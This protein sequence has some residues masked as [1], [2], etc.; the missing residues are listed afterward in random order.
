MVKLFQSVSQALITSLSHQNMLR[1]RWNQRVSDPFAFTP[2]EER[3]NISLET[4]LRENLELGKFGTKSLIKSLGSSSQAEIL[5]RLSHGKKMVGIGYG[6]GY[7]AAS[8]REVTLKGLSTW[9]LEISDISC[10]WAEEYLRAQFETIEPLGGLFQYAQP[11]VRR[12]EIRAALIEPESIGLDL[13]SIEIWYV[14]RTLGCLSERSARIVLQVMGESLSARLDP[15]KQNCI[16][17]IVALRDDNPT[18]IGC[19]S[20]LYSRKM[21]MSNVRRGAKRPIESYPELEASHKYFS[22]NYTAMTLRAK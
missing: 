1:S 4:S 22:Q 6:K 8:V 20:K 15:D 16:V 14:C 12:C 9:W 11:T 21:I 7:D 2:H 5:A 17:L 19:T 10:A 13:S 3:G 18:R